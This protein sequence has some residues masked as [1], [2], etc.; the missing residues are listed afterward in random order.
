MARVEHTCTGCVPIDAS[1]IDVYVTLVET[2]K[3]VTAAEASRS[4]A[5]SAR[6]AAEAQRT[7]AFA[8]D[9]DR[10]VADHSIAQSDHAT[11][12]SDHEATVA[13]TN[14]ANAAAAVANAKA[15]L[16][17]ARLDTADAD[18]TRAEGDHG[19]AV[20]DHSTAST[21][22]TMA[23][24]DHEAAGND[25]TRAESDHSI[26]ASDHTASASAT[27]AATGAAELANTKAGLVQEKLDRADTDHA[28]AES[29]HTIATSDH[30]AATADHAQASADHTQAGADHGTAVAD[31]TSA[32]TDHT[33]AGA[34][35]TLA[36]A[37]HVTAGEDHEQAL[38]DHQV[39]AGY[40]TRLG[41]VEGEVSQLRQEVTADISQLEA[42][43]SEKLDAEAVI[44]HQWL[45]V[46]IDKD[47]KLLGG[48]K[49]DGGV[50]WMVGVPTPVKE[51]INEIASTKEDKVTG[52][53]LINTDFANAHFSIESPEYLELKTDADGKILSY[54]DL[55]GILHENAGISTE[56]LA[57][58]EE[59]L[60]RF[61]QE[62]KASGFLSGVCDWSDNKKLHLPEP[63]CA[64][65]N[66]TNIV[67]MPSTKTDNAHAILE[68][69]D[70]AGNYFKKEVIANA[71]GRS[72]LSHPKK[73]ISIDLCNNNGWD[74]G[75]TFSLQI[76]SW[77]PQDSFHLKA[78]YNDPFR[79]LCPVGYKL[80]DE[81]TKTR[82]ELEDYVWKKALVDAEDTT[83]TS[84]GQES[85]EDATALWNT[86]ARCFP[87]GFPCIV[88][89][90][91]DFYGIFSW[92][93]KK[94][95]DNYRMS[96][97]KTN[98]IHLD[99]IISL[100]RILNANGDS[101]LI[102]WTTNSPE[103]VEIRNPKPKKSKDGWDLLIMD[104]TK[105]DADE[106]GG[107]LIDDS[108]PYWD[109]ND[110]SCVKTKQV[111]DYIL[112]L[113]TVIPTLESAYSTYQS[114]SKT[115]VDKNTFKQVFE[116]YFDVDNL[117]DYLIFSDLLANYDGFSQNVQWVTYDGVKWYLCPYDVDGIMGN[118]WQLNDTIV[119]PKVAHYN[120]A[121]FQYLPVFYNSELVSRYAELRRCGILSAN[122][123]CGFVI[124]WINRLGNKETFELEWEKWPTFIKNDNI[125][126]LYKWLVASISNMDQLYD[127]N[128]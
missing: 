8:T 4:E 52:K 16:V 55:Q 108:S 47:G 83:P 23:Q 24:S 102:W 88:Y 45:W 119:E 25:H 111:K 51:Y 96:K 50:E 28:R 38:A 92:Q 21:D 53:S 13:A 66:F 104:G 122:H 9:H 14:A 84:T 33:Q 58:S 37:D 62:L 79:C 90:N 3:S 43:V 98:N 22:H 125:H 72:S 59:G 1:I 74:D 69:W 67:A 106:N 29:D 32:T 61:K 26:A 82:G 42:E 101:S 68:F 112:N 30:T 18:H 127:Y 120:Y 17:Q 117:I 49:K 116:T 75:D 20:S 11:A 94:H 77:I 99:G 123:I 65:L 12:G 93:L 70:M 2:N 46:I 85:A 80:F 6:V 10:A 56:N 27:A 44:D 31:H 81:I 86:G 89:L 71:Q 34:D 91:G 64:L 76:G 97:K 95:R 110:Q 115:E 87:D 109:A 57:L 41:N 78:F 121:Q 105:Y 36:A 54:R 19:T 103:G 63:A 15:E 7:A 39:M 118:W 124:D 126:R 100:E 128:N 5:E 107:E 35:H 113:S 73:N 114:S 60:T 48:I 40:D